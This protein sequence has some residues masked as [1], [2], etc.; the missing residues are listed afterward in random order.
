MGSATLKKWMML[1]RDI[2]LFYAYLV[3]VPSVDDGMIDADTVH[4]APRESRYG[5]V[6]VLAP[7]APRLGPDSLSLWS[8]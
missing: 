7:S 2:E 4:L 1:A 6:A 3:G 5:R 8:P